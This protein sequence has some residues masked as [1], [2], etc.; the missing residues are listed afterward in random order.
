[1]P[2]MLLMYWREGL[3]GLLVLTILG[4]S[5]WFWIDRKWMQADLRDMTS[6]YSA[7]KSQHDRDSAEIDGF[8]AKVKA[9]QDEAA[10]EVAQQKEVSDKTIGAYDRS[11]RRALNDRHKHAVPKKC[12]D[13]AKYANTQAN[14]LGEW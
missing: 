1:M 10:R 11:L 5:T 4:L 9:V 7:C 3:I 8:N 13:G 14:T 12:E 6:K 2:V